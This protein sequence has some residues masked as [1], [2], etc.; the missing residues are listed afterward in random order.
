MPEIKMK[1]KIIIIIM[2]N[3]TPE[4]PPQNGTDPPKVVTQVTTSPKHRC[5]K[6]TKHV[7]F[8]NSPSCVDNKNIHFLINW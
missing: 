3:I 6:T 8:F 1:I 5:I 2:G 7:T 4:F